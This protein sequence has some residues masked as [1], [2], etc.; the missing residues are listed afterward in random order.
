MST[1]TRTSTAT[2]PTGVSLSV[3]RHFELLRQLMMHRKE[4]AQATHLAEAVRNELLVGWTPWID[5]QSGRTSPDLTATADRSAEARIRSIAA[6]DAFDPARGVPLQ[7][8]LRMSHAVHGEA[9]AQAGMPLTVGTTKQRREDVASGEYRTIVGST[10]IPIDES[11]RT[12]EDSIPATED[13]PEQILDT[14]EQTRA[15]AAAVAATGAKTARILTSFYGLGGAKEQTAAEIAAELGTT[16]VAVEMRLTR[17]RAA[18]ATRFS[19]SD[20][21]K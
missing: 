1:A 4:A 14:A 9:V 7:T 2:L 17:G 19:V 21:R 8:W 12:W 13:G 20:L 18:I 16:V 3:D 10:S 11:G 6:I 15:I 5:R